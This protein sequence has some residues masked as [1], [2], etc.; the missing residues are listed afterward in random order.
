MCAL[1]KRYAFGITRMLM[2]GILPLPVCWGWCAKFLLCENF[3]LIIFDMQI[4]YSTDTAETATWSVV[5]GISQGWKTSRRTRDKVATLK[6]KSM[7]RSIF[8]FVSVPCVLLACVFFES[9][10]CI[11]CV[12][13]TLFPR[14]QQ[15]G[16]CLPPPIV[17][18]VSI[19]DL[20]C[21]GFFIFY[22]SPYITCAAWV[23]K[24]S[25]RVYEEIAN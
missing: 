9:H 14:L 6:Q 24:L 2:W 8:C 16:V 22:F 20:A 7:D 18:Y 17:P 15:W 12:I 21:K 1:T 5:L 4:A 13:Y 3:N 23:T 10:E 25:P 11:I 19:S